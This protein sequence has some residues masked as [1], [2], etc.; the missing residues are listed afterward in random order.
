MEAGGTSS[1]GEAAA[2][3]SATTGE[4]QNYAESDS[5]TLD[6]VEVKDLSNQTRK[7]ASNSQS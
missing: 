5:N 3:A 4:K 2:S 6:Q 1:G 7:T